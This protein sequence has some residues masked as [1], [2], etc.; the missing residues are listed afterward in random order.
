MMIFKQIL[1]HSSIKINDYQVI[2][3]GIRSTQLQTLKII[4]FTYKIMCCTSNLRLESFE[5]RVEGAKHVI[6]QIISL[7]L[8]CNSGE[9]YF[10]I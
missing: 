7:A 10:A 5:A 4:I 3:Y 2:K 6:I 1:H 8:V 9:F